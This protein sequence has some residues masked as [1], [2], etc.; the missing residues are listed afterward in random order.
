MSGPKGRRLDTTV[1]DES[2]VTDK[3][4][5]DAFWEG[6]HGSRPEEGDEPYWEVEAYGTDGVLIYKE[7]LKALQTALDKVTDFLATPGVVV[8][9]VRGSESPADEAPPMKELEE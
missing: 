1:F 9:I 8:T 7:R 5:I 6:F 2:V 3:K 4:A